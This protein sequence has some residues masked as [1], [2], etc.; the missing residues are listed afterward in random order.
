ML[1]PA[2]R[3]KHLTTWRSF[4]VILDIISSP[5][6][7]STFI[8]PVQQPQ[9][10]P[11]G[12]PGACHQSRVVPLFLPQHR[13]AFEGFQISS[14]NLMFCDKIWKS[15][16]SPGRNAVV[17][18]RSLRWPLLWLRICTC[19]LHNFE[20]KEWLVKLKTNA[21]HSQEVDATIFTLHS[22]TP[23][24][25]M[26][27]NKEDPQRTDK[28]RLAPGHVLHLNDCP[29]AYIQDSCLSSKEP[30]IIHGTNESSTS[31]D[32]RQVGTATSNLQ[33]RKPFDISAPPPTAARRCKEIW[34][35][36]I[37]RYKQ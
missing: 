2:T 15:N 36:I 26:F 4:M 7:V 3:N 23:C 6:S 25:G 14:R 35:P 17:M 37:N 19:M 21:L 31:L 11:Q 5:P 18:T 34:W 22:W 10:F 16:N 20:G 28:Y 27:L 29:V 30:Q 24:E 12:P 9:P 32:S 1:Q 8:T 33:Q 13:G